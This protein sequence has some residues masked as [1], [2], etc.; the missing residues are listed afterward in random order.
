M[1]KQNFEAL[2]AIMSYKENL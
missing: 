2:M 1:R